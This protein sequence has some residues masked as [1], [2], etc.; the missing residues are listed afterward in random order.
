MS[1]IVFVYT[2][3]RQA[4]LGMFDERWDKHVVGAA[5]PE[6]AAEMVKIPLGG[7]AVIVPAADVTVVTSRIVNEVQKS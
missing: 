5:T 2:P 3:P 7:Q 6:D 1:Y 4:L